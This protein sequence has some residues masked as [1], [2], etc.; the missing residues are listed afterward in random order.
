MRYLRW[1]ETRWHRTDIVE[2]L[3]E[4]DDEGYVERL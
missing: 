4:F 1:P 3:T 2:M